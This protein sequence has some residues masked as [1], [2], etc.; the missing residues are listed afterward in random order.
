MGAKWMC[1]N[2]NNA[3]EETLRDNGFIIVC[4]KT[5]KIKLLNW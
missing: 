2:V 3:I 4:N 1:K 5:D